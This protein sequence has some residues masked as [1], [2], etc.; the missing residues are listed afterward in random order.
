MGQ[1]EA[2][3]A[4]RAGEG[5]G[6]RRRE[7]QA[8]Q[9]PGIGEHLGRRAAAGDGAAFEH[10]QVVAQLGQIL[11]GMRR[12]DH[13]H[14][15]AVQALQQLQE[16]AAPPGVEPRRGL[17]QHEHLRVHGQHPGQGRAALLAARK[18]EG[19]AGVHRLV[20]QPHRFQGVAHPPV[21]RGG[22][23]PQVARAEG[24]V[25]VDGGGEQLR[26]GVLEHHAYAGARLGG[27]CLVGQ[28]RPAEAHGALGGAQKAVHGLDE[29]ALA[30]AG[31]PGQPEEAALAHLEGHVVQ[32]LGGV[33]LGAPGAGGGGIGAAGRGRLALAAPLGF[34]LAAV[35]EA[36]ALV[37]QQHGGASGGRC[38]CACGRCRGGCGGGHS[39]HARRL[40]VSRV[41]CHSGRCGR[42]APCG[43]FPSAFCAVA[44]A[45]PALAQG[46]QR[47]G[48]LAVGQGRRGGHSQVAQL[49]GQ[50]GHEGHVQIQAAQLVATGE[51]LGRGAVQPHA[52]LVEHHH[53]LGIHRFLHEVGDA[54]DGHALG[55]QLPR[56]APQRRAPPR[57]EHGRGLVQHE[58]RR[59]E[60]QGAGDGH[61]LLL[62]AGQAVHLAALEALQAHL[63]QRCFHAL[64]QLGRG[65]AQVL[66][67]EGHVVLHQAGHQLVIGALEHQPR[68]RADEEQVGR[69]VGATAEHPHGACLG[70]QQRVDELRQG[71]LARPVAAQQAQVL[72]LGHRQV[73]AVEHQ[74]AVAVAEA[75]AHGLACDEGGLGGPF[76]GLLGGLAGGFLGQLLGSAFGAPSC[77]LAV[78]VLRAL[79]HG[80]ISHGTGPPG[81]PR[82]PRGRAAAARRGTPLRPARRSA[83]PSAR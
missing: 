77:S 51:H 11:H 23:E 10:Q 71:R 8:V 3:L 44:L 9:A 72:A 28:V 19:A 81:Q 17:V 15:L 34:G 66:G 21:H 69:L 79:T 26:L 40:R 75:E 76:R 53:A 39:R 30:A 62:A 67:A 20:G 12:H 73:E 50:L 43:G 45:R 27:R 70:H 41:C 65:H 61:A 42:G 14:A 4:Q 60:R 63:G 80:P 78:G 46:L 25:V 18:L 64:P 29:G 22:V 68:V 6:R 56:H 35:G 55:M 38:G 47:V 7:A 82:C 5:H 59:L 36:H 83:P 49:P 32:G 1:R 24:H 31:V 33:G 37:A 13:G 58:Q 57:V 48:Q 54:D 16:A 74:R 2:A 52:A